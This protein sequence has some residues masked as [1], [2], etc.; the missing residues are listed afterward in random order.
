[1]TEIVEDTHR[2]YVYLDVMHGCYRWVLRPPNGG[3]I[4]R[5]TGCYMEKSSCLSAA[6]ALKLRYPD[7]VLR[8]LTVSA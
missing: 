3:S 8:D 1:M 6:E 2:L 5:S 4:A 7:T